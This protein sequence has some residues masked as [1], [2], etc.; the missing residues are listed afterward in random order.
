MSSPLL[1]LA[2]TEGGLADTARSI[3]ETFGFNWSAF[4]SNAIAFLLVAAILYFGAIKKIQVAL[5]DRRQK[6]ADSLA[7]AERM[8]SELARAEEERKQIL[9]EAGQHAGR[10]IEEAR[11]VAASEREKA[12]QQAVTDAQDIIAKAR[13]ANEADLSRMK[14]ELR[15]EFGRLVVQA[16]VHVSGKVLND[17]DQRRLAEEANQQLAA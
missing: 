6:I 3:G 13:A 9:A 1:F 10:I 7:A 5:E 16:S 11:A 12:R 15:R 4:I 17:D 14:S 8:K 2:A